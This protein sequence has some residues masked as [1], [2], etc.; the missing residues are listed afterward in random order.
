MRFLCLV[1]LCACGS[2]SEDNAAPSDS[3]ELT[4]EAKAF[5]ETGD[6]KDGQNDNQVTQC[7]ACGFDMPGEPE[8]LIEVEGYGLHMCG[9]NCKAGFEKNLTASLNAL[10]K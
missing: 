1:F 6:L 7:I 3:V 5:L 4:S 8:H 10:A 9:A 2:P